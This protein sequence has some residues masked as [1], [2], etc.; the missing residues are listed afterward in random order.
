[1]KSHRPLA[2]L[3]A[4][5]LAACFDSGT[6]PTGTP[7][8]IGALTIDFGGL[9]AGT[10]GF[11]RLD[12]PNGAPATHFASSR[13][14]SG[15]AP[16]KYTIT[17]FVVLDGA[18]VL[19]P[20]PATQT[21]VIEANESR[22]VTVTY[23][24]SLA[25]ELQLQEIVGAGAGISSPIDLQAPP[26]DARLF[27]AER[28]GRLRI[29]QNDVLLA[30]PFLDISSR[31][32][33]AGEGGLL[34]FAFH[35]QFAAGQPFVF[36]HYTDPAQDIVVERYRVSSAD[37]DR[38]ET[39]GVEIIRIAHA[40][41]TNHY[42]G[43]VAFGP[44]GMLFLSTGDGG[45]G[46]DP[47][48]N[49]QNA[50]TLLGKMLRLDVA[51]LPYS[52]P[53]GNPLWSGVT[54][55]RREN[56]AIGLRNPWRYAFDAPSGLLYIADVGEGRREEV[57]AVA[58]SIAG[59][60]YGWNTTEGTLCFATDP[61]ITEGLTAPLIDYDHAQ[62]CSIIGGYVYRGAALPEL[63]G[64]YLYS[65]LCG[66]WLRSLRYESGVL[67]EEL[68]WSARPGASP[69]SFGVDGAGEIYLLT[70]DNRVLRLVR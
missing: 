35:P 70:A 32:S 69:F 43:R 56:W 19:S 15:G 16:G 4:L 10:E 42:G 12:G 36:V 21:V 64:R 55:A 23:T 33:I 18:S 66:G 5:L 27:I 57:S 45:G 20:T 8:S 31:V 38:L 3:I 46:G 34:S 41:F 49:G 28:A 17:A 29:V 25:F 47:F 60:N 59:V 44:D 48:A 37:P 54:N 26:G 30:T 7:P 1:M 61:C 50:A 51:A 22:P 2:A 52:I 6:V 14:F 13:T 65:D 24:A 62:G 40:S 68:E 58:A 11:A 39:T 53:A 67:T 63:H 9:P